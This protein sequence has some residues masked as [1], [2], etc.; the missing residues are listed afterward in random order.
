MNSLANEEQ[1]SDPEMRKKRRVDDLKDT[2]SSLCQRMG[3]QCLYIYIYLCFSIQS[4]EK[5]KWALSNI[6]I[7]KCLVY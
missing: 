2:I 7:V 1:S 5:E 3:W 4:E 6:V